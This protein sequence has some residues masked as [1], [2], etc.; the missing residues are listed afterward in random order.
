[1]T[2]W[3]SNLPQG[4]PGPKD[5]DLCPAN[6][7]VPALQPEGLTLLNLPISVWPFL[8]AFI[9]AACALRKSV[10]VE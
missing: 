8:K 2:G 10:C 5:L 4:L 3:I 6:V 7:L 9:V 1:M